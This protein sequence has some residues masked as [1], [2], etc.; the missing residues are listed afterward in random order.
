MKIEFV[1]GLKAI[2]SDGSDVDITTIAGNPRVGCTVAQEDGK[3]K[4]TGNNVDANCV[5]GVC[6]A[7][8]GAK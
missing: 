8:K 6:D 3:W 7:W 4:V 5:N 1:K 2:L